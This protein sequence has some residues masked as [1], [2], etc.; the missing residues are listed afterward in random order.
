MHEGILITSYL[1][2]IKS[3]VDKG[4]PEK[5]TE[6][7]EGIW[8]VRKRKE[9]QERQRSQK[10]MNFALRGIR[11]QGLKP[12]AQEKLTENLS[13]DWTQFVDHLVVNDLTFSVTR[14]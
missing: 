12:K 8:N 14:F 13:I 3:G 9:I 10:Y 5:I 6:S 7:I 2:R 4:W 11:T 1:H